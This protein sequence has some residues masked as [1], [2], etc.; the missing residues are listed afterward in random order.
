MATRTLG[1]L[2][3]F[4][5]IGSTVSV[6]AMADGPL[7]GLYNPLGL[8]VGAGVGRA[9]INQ[10]QFDEFSDSFHHD[11]GEPL[12][13]NAVIGLRP[14]PFLGAEAEYLDFGHSRLDAGHPYL[15]GPTSQQFLGGEAHDQA[16]AIFAVGY[17]PVPVPWMEPFA[18]LGWGQIW[19]NGHNTTLTVNGSAVDQVTASE[20]SRPSGAAYGGG[21]QFHFSQ[22]AVRAQYE[23]ISGS[24][25]F[26]EWNNPALL[27]VGLNWTF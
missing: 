7:F 25:S 22:L 16:A 5:L 14:I 8:Y 21:V 6:S 12:G 11:D 24:R 17:L 27:S 20:S 1:W 2:V 4:T 3:G 23:R 10:T 18:K 9:T 13:W 19:E 26:G 15:V